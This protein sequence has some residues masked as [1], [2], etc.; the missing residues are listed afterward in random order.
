MDFPRK[1]AILIGADKYEHLRPL[2]YCGDDVR[3]VAT[4]FRRSLQFKDEDILEFRVGASLAPKRQDILVKMAKFLSDGGGVHQDE[5]LIFY[6]SGHGV[7]APD[8]Q[9]DYLLPIDASADDLC[10]TGMQVEHLVKQLTKTR[11]KNIVMFID[12]C[13]E[14]VS[15]EKGVGSMGEQSR[16]AL[17]REGIVTFFACDPKEKSY[18]I[19]DLKHGSFTHCVLNAIAKGDCTT[20]DTIDKYLRENV[21]LINNRYRKP[22]QRPFT[23]IKPAEKG[24]LAIFFREVSAPVPTD[25][26]APLFAKLGELSADDVLDD[27][28]FNDAISLLERVAKSAALNEMDTRKLRY[29]D[30]LCSGKFTCKAFQVAW[31]ALERRES[32]AAP[33]VLRGA[34]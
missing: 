1:R 17:V 12:A 27:K 20:V 29:V 13:R 28:C 34:P 15:G 22:P 25:K 14:A 9:K 16:E 31:E 32:T 4:E 26:Y 21:P 2:D 7:I 6:F 10:G 11:C 8:D 3:D 24:Q 5:L 18:E 19:S 23:I 30:S 33:K